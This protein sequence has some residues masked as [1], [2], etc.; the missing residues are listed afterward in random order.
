M[1]NRSYLEYLSIIS[2]EHRGD[3][4]NYSEIKTGDGNNR[5]SGSCPEKI[6][7]TGKTD[8]KQLRKKGN[9]TKKGRLK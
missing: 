9:Q 5:V 8:I 2:T 7:S 6:E 3:W 1:N 4:E